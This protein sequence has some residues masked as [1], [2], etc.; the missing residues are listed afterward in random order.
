MRPR[1]LRPLSRPVVPI[2]ENLPALTT[3]SQ[4]HDVHETRLR[5]SLA[6]NDP[7]LAVQA[8]SQQQVSLAES[9]NQQLTQLSTAAQEQLTRVQ[10]LPQQVSQVQSGP[11]Q[12]TEYTISPQVRYVPESQPQRVSQSPVSYS[13]RQVSPTEHL[14]N[15]EH[16]KPSRRP[17]PPEQYLRETTQP[18]PEQ[19]VVHIPQKQQNSEPTLYFSSQSGQQTPSNSQDDDIVSQLLS[20]QGRGLFPSSTPS[21]ASLVEEI[22]KST[23][24]LPP[25]ASRSS[26][27]V[28]KTSNVK[29][30]QGPN[31]ITIEEV[32]QVQE[33]SRTPLPVVHLPTPEGQRP[34]T[35]SELQALIDAG[36]KISP[37]PESPLQT[38]APEYYRPTTKTQRSYVTPT[39]PQ[40][41][42]VSYQ[43][44]HKKP[45]QGK[46]SAQEVASLGVEGP[47]QRDQVSRYKLQQS[48]PRHEEE[49]TVQYVRRPENQNIRQDSPVAGI[50]F[51]TDKPEEEEEII[52]FIRIPTTPH[53]PDVHHT[54]VL[55]KYQSDVDRE[56]PQTQLH[57]LEYERGS[58]PQQIQT[59][60]Y[61]PQSQE[62]NY[63]TETDS[64]PRQTP[65]YQLGEENV[66]QQAPRFHPIIVAELPTTTPTPSPAPR[67]RRPRPGHS[68]GAYRSHPENAQIR[69]QEAPA[70]YLVS[71]DSVPEATNFGTRN[72]RLRGRRPVSDEES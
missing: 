20:Q 22:I 27:Y 60:R 8:L 14:S 50:Q 7:N 54:S 44:G 58:V 12:Q 32:G 67:R 57:R 2:A 72:S 16:A 5:A 4:A 6:G 56:A 36:F 21:D 40:R 55:T 17:A 9:Y 13:S 35:Q 70:Q 30:S 37:A 18:L 64:L 11:Q 63:Q 51:V 38:A 69:D 3:S 24:S 62:P 43:S 29:N 41:N 25:T 34:L 15:S 1:I 71:Y 45:E 33:D 19:T 42:Q 65:T 68:R 53:L 10:V 28:S 46:E 47:R 48:K 49:N 26:I 66:S 23:T 31:R 52:H 39:P 61:Q 59:T